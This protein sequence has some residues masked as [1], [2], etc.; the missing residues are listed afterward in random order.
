MENLSI[1]AL[2]AKVAAEAE[3]EMKSE[4]EKKDEEKKEEKKEDKQD[5]EKTAAFLETLANTL[6]KL[7]DELPLDD[8]VPGEQA[9]TKD[10]PIPEHDKKPELT[11][12]NEMKTDE[13]DPVKETQN[14]LGNPD[15]PFKPVTPDAPSDATSAPAKT[16]S[17]LV[18]LQRQKIAEA[19]GYDSNPQ[20]AHDRSA[21]LHNEGT[22]VG[23]TEPEASSGKVDKNQ[24]AI[25][26]TARTLAEPEKKDMAALLEEPMQ[27]KK[28]DKVLAE[29]LPMME[30]QAQPK[31]GSYEEII[32]ALR[33]KTAGKKIQEGIGAV[34]EIVTAPSQLSAAITRGK[35]KSTAE[36]GLAPE[37]GKAY[38]DV[39]RAK[40]PTTYKE[41][42]KTTG[43]GAGALLGAAIGAVAGRRGKA[44]KKG[45]KIVRKGQKVLR[46]G[47]NLKALLGGAGGAAIGAGAGRVTGTMAGEAADVGRRKVASED[48]VVLANYM[49]ARQTELLEEGA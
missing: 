1:D 13:R 28:H 10:A 15:K 18:E 39:E 8:A 33:A 49:R 14:H 29:A 31:V 48:E 16:A 25:D 21:E 17:F 2:I 35:A 45:G 32:N 5:A 19:L 34:S 22:Q 12:S 24:Q 3:E 7:A 26:D 36:K 6:E 23:Y 40:L 27:S 46:S 47:S 41:K 44:L 20:A 38:T 4:E 42:G 11:Q 43:T 9:K 30:P 37:R